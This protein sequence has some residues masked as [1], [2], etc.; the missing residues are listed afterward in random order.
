MFVRGAEPSPVPPSGSGRVTELRVWHSSRRAWR[1]V[2][3]SMCMWLVQQRETDSNCIP[4]DNNQLGRYPE[5][6]ET[7]G[8][9]IES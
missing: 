1:H 5:S 8:L 7:D 4:D 2:K 9:K 3:I 6:V